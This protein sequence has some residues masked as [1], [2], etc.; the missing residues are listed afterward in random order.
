MTQYDAWLEA[1]K[2]KIHDKFEAKREKI[3]DE[4]FLDAFNSVGNYQSNDKQKQAETSKKL[5]EID[6]AEAKE[7]DDFMRMIDGNWANYVDS[8]L[9][10]K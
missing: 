4:V 7:I 9:G 5:A 3:Q 2:M 10:N 8:V 6:A 1:E